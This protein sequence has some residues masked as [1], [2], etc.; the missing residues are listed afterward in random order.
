MAI[1]APDGANKKQDQAQCSVV[2]LGHHGRAT[3][4]VEVIDRL[5][6]MNHPVSHRQTYLLLPFQ[7]CKF[8]NSGKTKHFDFCVVP[9][10][11]QYLRRPG[12][13]R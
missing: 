4:C 8:R 3:W 9:I 5:L 11:R 7:I 2:D 1:R 13:I 12:C 10:F 6:E